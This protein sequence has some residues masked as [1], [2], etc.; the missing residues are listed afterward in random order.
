MQ[1]GKLNYYI[2]QL[3]LGKQEY[4]APFYQLTKNAVMYTALKVLHNRELAEEIMQETFISF[5]NS[6]HNIDDGKNFFAYLLTI[7]KNKAINEWKKDN[8]TAQVE[9]IEIYPSTA[10]LP[11][12]LIEL[13]KERL[14]PDEWQLLELCVIYQYRRVEVAQMKDMPIATVN[15]QYNQMLKK[16]KLLYKEVYNEK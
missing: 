9:D 11:T 13:C 2:S 4:F 3:K 15:W 5:I 1:D 14:S 10:E 12:P 16:V 6:L 7:A 8:Y